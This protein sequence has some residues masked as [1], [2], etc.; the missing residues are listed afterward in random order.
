MLAGFYSITTIQQQPGSITGE[1]IFNEAHEI[2]K[3][4]FP[5]VPVVP[6]VCMMQIMKQ[7]TAEQTGH[8]LLL[9]HAAQLK[10]LKLINPQI[11]PSVSFIIS[12]SA[13]GTTMEINAEF[14]NTAMSFFKMKASASI[15]T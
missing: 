12:W 8:T 2:F 15:K 7:I 1:I 6:G 3:G 11:T 14:R 10:F 13:A 5:S 4:H 9:T